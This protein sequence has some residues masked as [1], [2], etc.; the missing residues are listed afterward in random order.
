MIPI[1]MIFI[2]INYWVITDWRED[3]TTMMV[4]MIITAIFVPLLWFI[5]HALNTSELEKKEKS[6]T[7]LLLNDKTPKESI[8]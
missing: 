6:A 4:T 1:T 3:K 8:E 5:C 2:G 7:E